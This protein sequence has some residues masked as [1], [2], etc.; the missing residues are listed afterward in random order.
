MTRLSIIF[1]YF[2][3]SLAGFRILLLDSRCS[4]AGMFVRGGVQMS[5]FLLVRSIFCTE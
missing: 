4:G 3:F 1:D 5:P 2:V